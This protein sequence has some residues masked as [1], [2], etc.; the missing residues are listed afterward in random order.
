MFEDHPVRCLKSFSCFSDSFGC[1]THIVSGLQICIIPTK[2]LLYRILKCTVKSTSKFSSKNFKE[3]KLL[4]HR[5]ILNS[6]RLHQVSVMQC[7]W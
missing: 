6:S 7:I 5:S 3:Y 2:S 1:F 4:V